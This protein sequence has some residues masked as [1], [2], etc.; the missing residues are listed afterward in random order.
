MKVK[1]LCIFVTLAIILAN[2]ALAMFFMKIETMTDANNVTLPSIDDVPGENWEKLY[3]K[4]IFFGHQSVGFNIVDGI[5]EILNERD[6]IKLNIV[7]ASDPAEFDQ[8]VFAH[9]QVGRNTDPVSKIKSFKTIM[10]AGVGDKVDMAFFKF[11]YV[12]IMRDS[13]PQ[14]IFDSYKAAMDE[15]KGRYPETTFMHL[16]VP[17]CS[18]PKGAK[19]NLKQ[20][21]KLLIGRPGVLDDNIMRHRYNSLLM[22]AYS[23]T[24]PVFD[25]ALI[26]SVNPDGFRCYAEKGEEKVFV[27]VP[28]YTDDEGHLN[29]KG[30]K[31]TAEQL[32]ISLAEIANNL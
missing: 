16:T 15:L 20:S 11:C 17:V 24:E 25:L 19:R 18:A 30:R 27:M 10:D 31:K 8:P 4:K 13:D 26:E 32:L 14:S 1:T 5:S 9:S 29:G 3:E 23:K 22:E 2:C 7:E 6:N 21:V 28:E 12:D